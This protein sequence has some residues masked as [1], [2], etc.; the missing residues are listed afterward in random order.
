M[1]S[2]LS[3]AETAHD[4]VREWFWLEEKVWGLRDN[5]LPSKHVKKALI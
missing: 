1:S 4:R 5:S 2:F 3:F